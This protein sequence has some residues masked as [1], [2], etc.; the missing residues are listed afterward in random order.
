MLYLRE[1][2]HRAT[3]DPV[4]GGILWDQVWREGFD[5]LE[6]PEE[7]VVLGVRDGGLIEHVVAAVVLLDLPPQCHRRL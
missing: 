3:A 7:A 6:P 4:R 5:F 2:R 1:S